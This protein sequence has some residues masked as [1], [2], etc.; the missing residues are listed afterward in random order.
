MTNVNLLKSKMAAV[1]YTDFTGDLMNMLALSW[2]SASQRL[3]NK[4][5]FKQSEICILTTKLGLTGQDIKEIFA[6]ESE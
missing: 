2:T 6:S 4:A 1:G 5:E 3:N